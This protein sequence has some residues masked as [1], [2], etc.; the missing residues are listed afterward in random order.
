MPKVFILCCI[1]AGTWFPAFSQD[2]IRLELGGYPVYA[3]VQN[4]DTIYLATIEEAVIQPRKRSAETRDMRQYRKL[5]YNVKKVYPYAKLAGAKFG[6]VSAHMQTL[7]TNKEQREYIKQVEEEILK[8]YEED[9]KNLSITQGRI[10]IKLIDRETSKTS[11]EVVKELRGSFQAAFW[12][13][14]ARI[15]GSNLKT[16]FD[17]DGEDKVLNEIMI[18][19]EN[20]QL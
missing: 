15:F 8:E 13:A 10:L 7:K 2:T 20:G 9:L 11:F 12:Q 16:E 14:I 4:G 1:L 5:V 3:L 17:P 6:E 18:M 19:I